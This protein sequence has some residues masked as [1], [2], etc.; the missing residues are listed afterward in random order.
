FLRFENLQSYCQ[1]QTRL[2]CGR[3]ARLLV[4][5][6]LNDFRSAAER[7]DLFFGFGGKSMRADRQFLRELAVAQ[8]L[9]RLAFAADQTAF[10]ERLGRDFAARIERF[11]LSQINDDPAAAKRIVKAVLGQP[12]LERHLAAFESGRD[13][14][15]GARALAFMAAAGGLA[16]PGAIAASDALSFLSRAGCRL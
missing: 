16:V 2:L 13:V 14:A 10:V 12:P 9:H 7:L 11:E 1:T 4:R 5:Y 15:A 6:R 3:C 8:D